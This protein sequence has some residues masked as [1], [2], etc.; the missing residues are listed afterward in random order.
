MQ[1]F[2]HDDPRPAPGWRETPPAIPA[3][4]RLDGWTPGRQRAFLEYLADGLTVEAACRGVGLTHQS[5]YALRKRAC[6]ASFAAGWDAA[7]L[8][9]RTRAVD[10]GYSRAMEGYTETTTRPDGSVVS[11]HKFDNRLLT[12]TITRLDRLADAAGGEA[13]AVTR[14]IAANF[15]RFCDMIEFGRPMDIAAFAACAV[16]NPLPPEL[17]PVARLRDA[18]LYMR[19]DEEDAFADDENDGAWDGDEDEEDEDAEEDAED[20]IDTAD[21]IVAERQGWTADQWTRALAAGLVSLRP[22]G[23]DLTNP[24]LPQLNAGDTGTTVDRWGRRRKADPPPE[25]EPMRYF[26]WIFPDDPDAIVYTAFPPRAGFD[27]LQV[28]TYPSEAYWRAA[29]PEEAAQVRRAQSRAAEDQRREEARLRDE[30]LEMDPEDRD[31][32]E[33]WDDDDQESL[34]P[35]RGESD[36]PPGERREGRC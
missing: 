27:G 20:A 30:A 28:G 25:P 7:Y 35:S 2:P 12:A 19:E 15:D 1:T 32:D 4:Q 18:E 31:E 22:P 11:R 34:S 29:S 17:A 10:V 6:G 14:H 36:S 24:Q 9:A 33:D 8:H 3:R 23:E 13:G 26:V 21:L 16:R 5:A